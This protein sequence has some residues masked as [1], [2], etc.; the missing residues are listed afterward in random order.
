MHDDVAALA[1]ELRGVLTEHERL[2]LRDLGAALDETE[3]A[4]GSLRTVAPLLVELERDAPRLA[5]AVRLLDLAPDELEAATAQ[6]AFVA[7][8]AA[9]PLVERY[10]STLLNDRSAEAAAHRRAW[11]HANAGVVVGRARERFRERVNISTLPAAQ[12]T[13]EQKAF[14]KGYAAGRRELEH[15]FGKTM[16]YKSI[17]ELAGGRHRPRWSAT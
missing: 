17:R 11:L 1:D 8:A 9:D 7:A 2:P 16:R 14:K 3:A 12:L 13:P 15:E 10:G 6:R 5:R 4:A